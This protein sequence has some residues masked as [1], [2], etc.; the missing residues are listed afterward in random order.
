MI[1]ILNVFCLV[2]RKITEF[3]KSMVIHMDKEKAYNIYCFANTQKESGKRGFSL[4]IMPKTSNSPMPPV[5]P[6]KEKKIKK[7]K[8]QKK[9]KGD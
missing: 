7:E 3:R 2:I 8:K 5:I 4:P 6:P 1:Y 9:S